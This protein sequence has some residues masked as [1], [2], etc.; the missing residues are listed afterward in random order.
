MSRPLP[1]RPDLEHLRKQAKHLLRD[2]RAGDPAAAGR[3]HALQLP[4][5]PAPILADAQFEIAREHGFPSWARLKHHVESG[6]TGAPVS[7][8]VE[9]VRRGDAA[10]TRALLSAHP[11]LEERLDDPL[12][13]LAFGGTLLLEALRHDRALIEVLLDAGADVNQRSHWWAGSFG[14]LDR[15]SPHAEY[16]V[17]RGARVDAY[18][19]ARHGWHERLRAILAADPSRARMRGGDGQT[20][21]HV[22]ADVATA[23][24]L[25]AHGADIDAIDVDHESTPAQ[26]LVRDHPE[27]ARWLIERGARTDLLLVAALGD[28]ERVARHLAADPACIRM[29]VD[30]HWFPM[31]DPRAGGIIYIWTLGQD[32]NAFGVARDGGHTAVL[33]LL[34]RHRPA[35]VGLVEACEFGDDAAIARLLAATPDLA[36]RLE[37]AD[38]ARLVSAAQNADTETVHRML[39]AGWP[40]DALDERGAT[41][42]HWACWHGDATAVR[43]LLAHGAAVEVR[44]RQFD[45]TPLGWAVHGAS[46]SQR[47]ARGDHP[48][49]VRALV[50]AGARFTPDW[51]E[52]PMPEALRAALAEA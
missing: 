38:R 15:T 37:P 47:R 27:V 22:A 24:M 14:V 44:E 2:L 46:N 11:A 36:Q 13:G 19:A 32:Q 25:V 5:P 45:G 43:D 42:L 6:G 23:E 48:A 52:R 33:E 50:T 9:S 4:L 21:L 31:R 34:Q 40:T 16:L 39:A 12:P 1:A 26:Y 28:T 10:A 7:E 49:V 3:F 20:P 41:A 29:S 17:T 18:A 51:L 8:L 35:P 30:P